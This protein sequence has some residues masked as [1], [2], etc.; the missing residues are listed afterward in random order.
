MNTHTLQWQA[1]KRAANSAPSV[2]TW[3]ASEPLVRATRLSTRLLL[4]V[5]PALAIVVAA[6]WAVATVAD[7]GIVQAAIWASGFVFLALAMEARQPDVTTLLA[8]GLALPVIAWLSASVAAEFAIIA[9][10][11]VAAWVTVAIL[12][13]TR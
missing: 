13:R 4:A 9:A 8:T 11:A 12:R 7:S 2:A 3:Q 1:F 6:A 5:T 10:V